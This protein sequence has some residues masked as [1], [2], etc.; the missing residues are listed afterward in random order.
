LSRKVDGCKPL[1]L[2]GNVPSRGALA[3]GGRGVA[4]SGARHPL[5]PDIPMSG[6]GITS[7]QILTVN[8]EGENDKG[9]ARK[10]MRHLRS[11]IADLEPRLRDSIKDAQLARR[12]ENTALSHLASAKVAMGKKYAATVEEMTAKIAHVKQ[13]AADAEDERQALK[14]ELEKSELAESKMRQKFIDMRAMFPE[15]KVGRD[16]LPP[17]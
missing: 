1:A 14:K 16:R 15:L 17:G 13:F 2:G 10:E 5:M 7:D 3:A 9:Y 11:V 8:T 12:Q 4:F 6:A